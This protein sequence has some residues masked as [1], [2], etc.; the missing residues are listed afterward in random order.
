ML[1][2]RKDQI[3][4]ML[5]QVLKKARR[6]CRP[7]VRVRVLSPTLNKEP[8]SLGLGLDK[9]L[10]CFADATPPFA[11]FEFSFL[12]Y[13]EVGFVTRWQRTEKRERVC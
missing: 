2:G 7:Q 11:D 6:H 10:L 1:D 5:Q 13:L 3:E 8:H 9:L 12:E 4:V